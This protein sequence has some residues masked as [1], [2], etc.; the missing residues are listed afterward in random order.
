M[1]IQ[2]RDLERVMNQARVQLPGASDAGLK[3]VLFDVIDEFFDVSNSWTEWVNLT[4]TTGN[5][6]YQIYPKFGG[7]F[8]RLVTAID[9]N[10]V[11]QPALLTFGETPL[12]GPFTGGGAPTPSTTYAPPPGVV[13]TFV[14]P[15]NSTM[16][17]QVLL[18]KKSIL[19]NNKDDVPDAPSWLFPKY[20]RYLL[21]GVVGTMMMQK[22]KSYS[23]N[24]LGPYNLKRF[25][26]G[27][28]MAKTETM[29][30]NLLGGQAWRYPNTWR[31][32]S[33]RGGVSTPF[34]TPSGQGVF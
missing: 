18:T 8:N 12:G 23:D 20:A 5:Q 33:Q 24:S 17:V 6:V 25:R 34:P 28:D 27:M 32:N 2:E 14:N 16:T 10:N 3:G 31:S 29:R 19:P 4:L 11:V 1:A 13:L 30:S 21:S 22:S 26:D 15:V 7:M 9:T